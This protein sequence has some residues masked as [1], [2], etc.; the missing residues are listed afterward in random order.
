MS[1]TATLPNRSDVPSGD[2]WDLSSLYE[3]DEAWEKDFKHVDSLIDTYETFRGRLD[4]SAA[5]LAEAMIFDSDFDRTSERLGY[6]A[7]LRTTEDQSNSDYQAMK[8]RFQNLAV[9][10]SQ[11]ASYMRPE[12]LAIDEA[13]TQHSRVFA[14]S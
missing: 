12:L 13:K 4:E 3:S 8:A 2:C 14:C 6:Y 10:A 11:A 9:R 5:V 7:F 1:A